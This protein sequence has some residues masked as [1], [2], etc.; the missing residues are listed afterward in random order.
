MH[1]GKFVLCDEESALS[2]CRLHWITAAIHQNTN[3][4]KFHAICNNNIDNGKDNSNGNNIIGIDG[5]VSVGVDIGVSLIM[6][7]NHTVE[8]RLFVR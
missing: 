4:V 7:N 3:G 6:I 8:L 5:G 1:F 2:A